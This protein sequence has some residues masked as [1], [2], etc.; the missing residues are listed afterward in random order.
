MQHTV[1]VCSTQLPAAASVLVVLEAILVILFQA[2]NLPVGC[3]MAVPVSPVVRCDMLNKLF[4]EEP[5][6]GV[7]C[8]D[9]TMY[10]NACNPLVYRQ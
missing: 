7:C 10:V 5:C 9:G 4:S 1:C 6:E 2:V 8:V 3:P